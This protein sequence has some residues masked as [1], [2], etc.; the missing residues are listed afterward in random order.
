MER[1]TL[2]SKYTRTVP[3]LLSVL[4]HNNFFLAHSLTLLCLLNALSI[5]LLNANDH[6][7]AQHV[8]VLRLV[9]KKRIFASKIAVKLTLQCCYC[10]QL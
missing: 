9:Q 1:H 6:T 7:A 4:V 3:S 8:A 5:A 2:H 10:A